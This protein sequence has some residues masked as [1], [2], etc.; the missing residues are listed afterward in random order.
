M[1][2]FRVWDTSLPSPSTIP[3]RLADPEIGSG[4]AP[5]TCPGQDHPVIFS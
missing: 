1:G 4:D 3:I 2:T 5:G